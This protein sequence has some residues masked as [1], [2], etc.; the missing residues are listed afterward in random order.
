MLT[1]QYI[2]DNSLNQDLIDAATNDPVTVE[3]QI[4]SVEKLLNFLCVDRYL[5]NWK[6]VCR[7]TCSCDPI[8]PVTYPDDI[9]DLIMYILE[10][11][12]YTTIVPGDDCAQCYDPNVESMSMPWGFSVTYREDK[13]YPSNYKIIGWIS[14]PSDYYN[15]LKKYD[16][17]NLLIAGTINV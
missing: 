10:Q 11:K 13:T 2:L 7:F 8:V 4:K 6:P 3:K 12:Y 1:I 17:K 15:T 16:C 14:I 9:L 5:A